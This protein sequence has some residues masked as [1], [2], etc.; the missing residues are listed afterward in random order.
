M[1]VRN[2]RPCQRASAPSKTSHQ[3]AS[4]GTPAGQVV[5]RGKS[6]SRSALKALPPHCETRKSGIDDTV[7]TCAG[8]GSAA[9]TTDKVRKIAKSA[10]RRLGLLASH[11]MRCPEAGYR[12][13]AAGRFPKSSRTSLVRTARLPYADRN[14]RPKVQHRSK[15]HQLLALSPESRPLGRALGRPRASNALGQHIGREATPPP[16]A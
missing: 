16:G 5:K 11:Q 14:L 10:R 1:H 4:T 8:L 12:E 9:N 15:G 7:A 6:S 3:V 2:T 13:A